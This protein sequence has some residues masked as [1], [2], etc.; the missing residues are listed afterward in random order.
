MS[1][2]D[3]KTGGFDHKDLN[4]CFYHERE[5]ESHEKKEII[6]TGNHRSIGN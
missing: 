3:R 5:D 6:N 1:R 4:L 2:T